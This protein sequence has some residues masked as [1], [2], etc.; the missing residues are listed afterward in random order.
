M[1]SEYCQCRTCGTRVFKDNMESIYTS[2]EVAKKFRM[3]LSLNLV[4]DRRLPE[5][6]CKPCVM[7]LNLTHEFVQKALKMQNEMLDKFFIEPKQNPDPPTKGQATQ[8]GESVEEVNKS[9]EAS[10][11]RRPSVIQNMP[12]ESLE[13]TE[14][15]ENLTEGKPQSQAQVDSIISTPDPE[16]EV[17]NLDENSSKLPPQI[18]APP[19]PKPQLKLKP[20]SSLMKPNI[21][22]QPV[23][24]TVQNELGAPVKMCGRCKKMIRLTDEGLMQHMHECPSKVANTQVVVP[25]PRSKNKVPHVIKTPRPNGKIV[26]LNNQP[27]A[28]KFIINSV[29]LNNTTQTPPMTS[30]ASMQ[31]VSSANQQPTR[32]ILRPGLGPQV[33]QFYRPTVSSPVS[34]VV[35]STP[36]SSPVQGVYLP[37]TLSAQPPSIQN[38]QPPPIPPPAQIAPTPPVLSGNLAKNSSRFILPK[39][40]AQAPPPSLPQNEKSKLPSKDLEGLAVI[41]LAEEASPK[42]PNRQD[43]G[44]NNP[45]QIIN[46]FQANIEVDKTPNVKALMS[47]WN[48]P[49][50]S[51]CSL[52]DDEKRSTELMAD[53]ADKVRQCSECRIFFLSSIEYKGHVVKGVGHQFWQ[54]SACKVNFASEQLLK[55]HFQIGLHGNMREQF[56][57]SICPLF[58]SREENVF[59]H[60]LKMHSFCPHCYANLQDVRIGLLKRRR[61]IKLRKCPS[62]KLLINQQSEAMLQMCYNIDKN[63]KVYICNICSVAFKT[64]ASLTVHFRQNHYPLMQSSSFSSPNYDVQIKAHKNSCKNQRNEEEIRKVSFEQEKVASEPSD[65]DMEVDMEDP[66]EE[67]VPLIPQSED[68]IS[69]FCCVRCSNSYANFQDL[70]LH[71]RVSHSM[72]FYRCEKCSRNFKN[73]LDSLEHDCSKHDNVRLQLVRLEQLMEFSG[74]MEA[75][76]CLIGLCRICGTASEE[77][78][79]ICSGEIDTHLQVLRFQLSVDDGLP[80][81]ACPSCV[82]KLASIHEFV[83]LM[84]RTDECLRVM[85]SNS[86]DK[87]MKE[88]EEAIEENEFSFLDAA[89]DALSINNQEEEAEATAEPET[90]KRKMQNM[91][92]I[93]KQKSLCEKLAEMNS[94]MKETEQLNATLNLQAS[95]SGPSSVLELITKNQPKSRT[96]IRLDNSETSIRT[97]DE[98]NIMFSSGDLLEQHR[99]EHVVFRCH[100]CGANFNTAL[101]LASHLKR[102][103]H[104]VAL[105]DTKWTCSECFMVSKD[106]GSMLEHVRSVHTKERPYACDSCDRR[107]AV[108]RALTMHVREHKQDWSHVCSYCGK[109]FLVKEYYRI[110]VRRYHTLEKP[111]ECDRCDAKYPSRL[112]LSE[113]VLAKHEGGRPEQ[114]YECGICGKKF[115]G[116]TGFRYHV[117]T[118]EVPIEQRRKFK[119]DFC[120]ASFIRKPTLIKHVKRHCGEQEQYECHLCGKKLATSH[121]LDLHLVVH[122]GEKNHVCEFCGKAFAAAGTLKVHIRSHT[123]EKPYQCKFCP[124]RFTQRS[125]IKVHMRNV[126]Q[127]EDTVEKLNLFIVS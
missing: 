20:I 45:S 93:K 80:T 5:F 32:F 36:I 2:H 15:K 19:P 85:L 95:T 112:Q 88:A 12:K 6:I 50:L 59:K 16:P 51:H 63:H 102:N 68:K 23:Q 114:I 55:E 72:P 11:S 101:I 21:P 24:P 116:S 31:P 117:Q 22:T 84:Q 74:A 41:R 28:S 105:K 53:C 60:M 14:P 43:L 35:S 109:G 65:E 115:K 97:C 94:K 33:L 98:C 17:I 27:F 30:T 39:D 34:S 118:H 125:S 87:A 106:K 44:T 124:K 56:T 86:L 73:M 64:T 76:S 89:G 108:K 13:K 82:R 54:C 111:F 81:G 79:D 42:N 66:V 75:S 58:S 10:S 77:L 9:E 103:L 18:E 126:H 100:V 70:M 1:D 119:C 57:C 52:F 78:K 107:F 91:E 110:H 49:D 47:L 38:V 25:Q 83:T 26:L 69:R 122:S 92:N 67:S 37:S 113:H 7:E 120:D 121:G 127:Y 29:N 46:L 123:G 104:R 8:P 96:R 71:T 90:K 4:L 40:S 3:L 99:A 61:R 62:C 48:N